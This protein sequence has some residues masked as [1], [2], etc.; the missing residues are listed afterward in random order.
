MRCKKRV[1]HVS[2]PL[3]AHKYDFVSIINAPPYLD[4]VG[5]EGSHAEVVLEV[6][7]QVLVLEPHHPRV[8]G[9]VGRKGRS[10]LMQFVPIIDLVSPFGV[11]FFV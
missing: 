7:E 2:P 4:G 5:R 10:D 9:P 6:E 8:L 11:V 3:P 1:P